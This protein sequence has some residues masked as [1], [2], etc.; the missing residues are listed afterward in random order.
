MV[1][2]IPAIVQIDRRQLIE[3][4]RVVL[5]PCN[6]PKRADAPC[7][8]ATGGDLASMRDQLGKPR[9]AMKTGDA[10]RT[11]ELQ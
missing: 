2:S 4:R 8:S 11:F 9:C 5:Y 10:L 3:R 7:D 6:F 1:T